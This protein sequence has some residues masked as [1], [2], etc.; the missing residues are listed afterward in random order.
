MVRCALTVKDNNV[1]YTDGYKQFQT[2]TVND[3]TEQ[4]GFRKHTFRCCPETCRGK[5]GKHGIVMPKGN[6]TQKACRKLFNYSI[7]EIEDNLGRCNYPFYSRI[8]DCSIQGTIYLR[9][10]FDRLIHLIKKVIFDKYYVNLEI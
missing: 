1:C 8:E 3:N 4:C 5:T 6:F 2:C 9:N 7:P 10:I